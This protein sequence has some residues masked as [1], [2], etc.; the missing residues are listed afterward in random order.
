MNRTPGDDAAGLLALLAAR[1][2]RVTRTR[3]PPTR[4]VA[5]VDRTW[6]QTRANRATGSHDGLRIHHVARYREIAVGKSQLVP[7]LTSQ[8]V[9]N[10]L[11]GDVP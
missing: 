5:S 8:L 2:H 3:R 9:N 1:L 6:S 11:T 7:C 10:S 4:D